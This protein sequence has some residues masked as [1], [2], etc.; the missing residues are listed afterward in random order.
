MTSGM[1]NSCLAAFEDFRGKFSKLFYFF[2]PIKL[3]VAISDMEYGRWSIA[4]III[5]HSCLLTVKFF[6]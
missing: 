6:T 3:P 1:L 5:M 4:L 2:K